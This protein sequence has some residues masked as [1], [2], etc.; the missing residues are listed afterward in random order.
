MKHRSFSNSL[1]FYSVRNKENVS[2]HASCSIVRAF[3]TNCST[4]IRYQLIEGLREIKGALG[5]IRIE[6]QNGLLW[7]LLTYFVGLCHSFR[8]KL[9]TPGGN[10]LK[11]L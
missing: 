6:E 7:T 9:N 5:T 10:Y 3:R 2:E 11:S 8:M 1:P 4:K